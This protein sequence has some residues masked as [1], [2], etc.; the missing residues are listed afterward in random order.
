M[1]LLLLILILIVPCAIYWYD[2]NQY[3]KT[4]YYNA[5]KN[6]YGYMRSDKGRHGEYL[7]YACLRHFENDGGKFLF[8]VYLPKNGGFET[9][10][11]D[12]V[13]ICTKGL[14]VFESK[15]YSGWIFGNE[16][17]KNW[18]QTL[19]RGR[20]S[21]LKTSFYNPIMQNAGHVK[22]LKKI[23]G[24]DIPI[25]SIIVFSDS[26]TFK[27]VTVYSSD[28]RVINR[29]SVA[30]AVQEICEGTFYKGLSPLQVH[31]IYYR[32]FPYTQGD[33]SLKQSHISNLRKY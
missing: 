7:T 15:N 12:I 31:A 2:I 16:R 10:E 19:P 28:I 26:C 22:H 8:N 25:K 5:T 33:H 9:T 27:N 20:R 4:T 23:V 13:L 32:L 6:P 11:I 3:K 17:H 18:T 29:R 1:E 14:F 30:H 21:S 24:E